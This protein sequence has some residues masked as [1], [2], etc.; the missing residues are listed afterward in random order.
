MAEHDDGITRRLQS[1]F[2][3]IESEPIPP[4]IDRLRLPTDAP[5]PPW[6]SRLLV[7]MLGA[8]IAALVVIVAVVVALPSRRNNDVDASDGSSP[9]AASGL[10][11]TPAL[12]STTTPKPPSTVVPSLPTTSLTVPSPV[13]PST[14][15]T[16]TL[17][18][19]TS[20]RPGQ[21]FADNF[22]ADAVGQQPFGW[23]IDSG[24]WVVV[25]SGTAKALQGSQPL[26][27]EG[28]IANGST[29][30]T[31][32]TVLAG[33]RRD[34][35][36][37]A[38]ISVRYQNASNYYFCKIDGSQLGLGVFKNGAGSFFP[39]G[40][41]KLTVPVGQIVTMRLTVKG[42]ALQCSVGGATVGGADTGF[43]TGKMGLLQDGTATFSNVLVTS[44]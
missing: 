22:S 30:W 18:V 25:A 35:D 6:T 21:L 4:G 29:S 37:T 32:V 39:A 8:G 10:G 27:Q 31:D 33:V 12:R 9:P 20:T 13:V 38:G 5:R 28:R 17:P 42:S 24:T 44:A 7:P 11:S 26:G 34:A 2:A 14:T 41:A 43:T 15:T 16:T 1:Y 23:T 19:T 3:E 36:G 40:Q